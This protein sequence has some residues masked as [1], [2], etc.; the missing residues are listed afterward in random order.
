MFDTFTKQLLLIASALAYGCASSGLVIPP[1]GELPY[2]FEGSRTEIDSPDRPAEQYADYLNSTKMFP[3]TSI[4]KRMLQEDLADKTDPS[5]VTLTWATKPYLAK[6]TMW[7]TFSI[8]EAHITYPDTSGEDISETLQCFVGYA[9][10]SDTEVWR[11]GQLKYGG[12]LV[13]GHRSF[14]KGCPARYRLSA[15]PGEASDW[16]PGVYE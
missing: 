5:R 8:V 4:C 1:A 11:P 3:S 14:Y 10:Y 15:E 12:C 7:G 9:S 13:K 2:P 16:Y 6:G